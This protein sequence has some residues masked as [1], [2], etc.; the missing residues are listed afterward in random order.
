MFA[1]G[2][3]WRNEE[4]VFGPRLHQLKRL[5]PAFDNA[6]HWKCGWLA[7]LIRTIKLG[8]VDQGAAIIYGYGV[9]VLGGCA[10]AFFDDLVLQPA[11]SGFYAL[12]LLVVLKKFQ[13][14][15]LVLFA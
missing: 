15:R 14:I 3:V 13:R 12:L 9:G 6:T 5:A 2:K 1:V 10:T 8:P 7:A 4:L 11:G